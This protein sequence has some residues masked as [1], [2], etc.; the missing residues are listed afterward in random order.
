MAAQTGPLYFLC[1][2]GFFVLMISLNVN[3]WLA[4]A[5]S[6]G[7]GLATLFFLN[8]EAGHNSKSNAID[9]LPFIFAGITWLMNGK[10]TLGFARTGD[11]AGKT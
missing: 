11:S 6:L 9:Y 2:A 7:F 10:R 3:P 4:L 8:A 1:F 5:G